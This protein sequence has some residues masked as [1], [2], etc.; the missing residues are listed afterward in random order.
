MMTA[1]V[2]VLATRERSSASETPEEREAECA[3]EV[4]NSRRRRP[5]LPVDAD[6]R[7]VPSS[8]SAPCEFARARKGQTAALA[9]GKPRG[10]CD[11]GVY[12][13]PLP[14]RRFEESA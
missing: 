5:G 4:E 12:T 8:K 13:P 9:L 11:A 6:T 14:D 10:A 1:L 7:E 3:S 2:V